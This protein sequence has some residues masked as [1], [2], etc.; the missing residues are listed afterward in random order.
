MRQKVIAGNWKMYKTEQ[1]AAAYL[2]E[3]MP[4]VSETPDLVYLAVPFTALTSS[5][6]AVEGSSII[7][8]AQNMNDATE[9]AYTGEIAGRMLVSAGAKFV[10]LGH[11]ERRTFF[12]EDNAF[13]NKKVLR[14]LQEGIQPI[15]CVG[16]TLDQREANQTTEVLEGQLKACLEG[17]TPEQLAKF[18]IAYEPVWA[19][20]TG[21]TA[22]TKQAEEA[23]RSIRAM[24]GQ[25][26]SLEAAE[27]VMLIYGGSVKPNNAP[28]FMEKPDIDGLLVGAAA[29]K[30]DSFS[31]II[32]Y[33]S[34]I[35]GHEE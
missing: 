32:N 1:Q 34:F 21:E 13:I 15:L 11:S 5:V 24:I 8:G 19:I 22:T 18:I 17:V 33:R 6:K 20:G 29:L 26:W 14:A 4:L 35:K 25:Q 12:H 2:G 23:H 7:I 30:A 10:L 31:Q 3:L 9:G 28:Q 16:E 27:Q